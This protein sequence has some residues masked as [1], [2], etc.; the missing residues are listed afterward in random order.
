V[1]F[2]QRATGNVNTFFT[3]TYRIPRRFSRLSLG[4]ANRLFQFHK[5]SQLFIRVH[6]ETLSASQDRARIVF[7]R[8]MANDAASISCGLANMV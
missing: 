6:N 5:R 3:S 1:G 2:W 4:S 7:D 8:R